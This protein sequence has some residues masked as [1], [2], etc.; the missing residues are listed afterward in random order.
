M[1][2]RGRNHGMIFGKIGRTHACFT[3]RTHS[4]L[5]ACGVCGKPMKFLY[6]KKAPPKRDD[7]GWRDLQAYVDRRGLAYLS[8][9][10][11]HG[12][13]ITTNQLPRMQKMK[14]WKGHMRAAK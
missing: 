8:F 5:H 11:W 9:Y 3:C 6:G 14:T 10:G 12:K 7:R 4:K 1:Y 13:K 2:F